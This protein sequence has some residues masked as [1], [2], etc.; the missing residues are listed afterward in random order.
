MLTDLFPGSP[1]RPL[2]LISSPPRTV[3]HNYDVASG[4]VEADVYLPAG[5][6]KHGALVL[7]LGAVGFSRRDPVLTRLAD[8]LSRAG[9]VVMIPESSALAS[10]TIDPREPDTL[11]EAVRFLADQ[12]EVDPPRV[13]IVGFS[14]GGSIALLS[15]EDERIRDRLAFVNPFGAYDDA[16][17][18][19]RSVVAREIQTEQGPQPWEPSDLTLWVF[20]K[21]L[22]ESLPAGPEGELLT[23]LYLGGDETA[24]EELGELGS[25]AQTIVRLLDRDHPEA[26]DADLAALPPAVLERLRAISPSTHLDRLASR[27]YVMH[28]RSDAYI[29]YTESRRL[30][31]EAPPGTV[32]RYTEFE[33]FSHV[34]PDRPLPPWSFVAEAWKLYSHVYQVCL[35][36][37]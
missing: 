21:Q 31:A 33:L 4:H 32:R 19:L 9:A 28:D 24:R 36:I 34:M 5:G 30:V 6:G 13:G 11:I 10:G 7:F 15:A 14:V 12:P 1:V 26:V 23:R 8:G 29:P 16:R 3:E 35:E 18:L 17:R 22:V 20:K 25:D 37:L 27:L 2:T